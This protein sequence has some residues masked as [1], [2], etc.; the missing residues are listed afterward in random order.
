MKK[1]NNDVPKNNPYLLKKGSYIAFPEILEPRNAKSFNGSPG[2]SVCYEIEEVL[3]SEDSFGI[4][5]RA[6]EHKGRKKT[7]R[8]VFIKTPRISTDLPTSEIQRHLGIIFQSFNT[9]YLHKKVIRRLNRSKRIA[10]ETYDIGF[11][12]VSDRG[13]DEIVVPYLVQEFIEQDS[14]VNFFNGTKKYHLDGKFVGIQDPVEWFQLAE[15]IIH[16]VRRV[17]NNQIIHGEIEPKNF[18]ISII[19]GS[20]HPVLVDFGKSFLLDVSL[21]RSAM[22]R[23]GN[24]YV[25]P[26]CR[27]LRD[28]YSTT[29]DIYALG[30]VLFYLS[31]GEHP[32]DIE[33]WSREVFAPGKKWNEII[34]EDVELWKDYIHSFFKRNDKLMHTNEGIVKIIDKCLRPLPVDRYASADKLLQALDSVNYQKIRSNNPGDG[35]EDL[36]KS[37][38]QLS[39]N[40]PNTRKWDPLFKNIISDKVALL[41][42][43][44]ADMARGHFEIYGEREDLIDSLVKYISVLSQDDTYITVTVPDYWTKDNLGVN[45]RFLTVNKDLVRSGVHIRRLFLVSDEDLEESSAAMKILRA[46]HQAQVDLGKSGI[47]QPTFDEEIKTGHGTMYVGICK[48]PTR[49]ELKEYQKASSHVA[50][51]HRKE[52]NQ[53]ISIIFSSR[54]IFE[55]GKIVGSQIVKVRFRQQRSP[56]EYE[57]MKSMFDSAGRTI[58]P[59][60]SLFLPKPAA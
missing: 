18:L 3:S 54:P 33:E 28:A 6:S 4:S 14:L 24:S 25:A 36:E 22:G 56:I 49:D 53:M 58:E 35:G 32:P 17:H 5:Y 10:A 8:T 37:L 1:R 20:L 38:R 40:V 43:E 44:M 55:K 60:A 39:D 52:T 30:G 7:G 27:N 29:A 19:K 23:S 12:K 9:E 51:W 57:I 45:G 13:A 31:T 47:A 2:N 41:K 34:G 11:Y 42:K 46:H 26:E 21:A 15:R 16:I 59:I 50:I 48:F